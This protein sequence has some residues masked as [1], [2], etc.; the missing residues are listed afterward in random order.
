M[1]PA[2]CFLAGGLLGNLRAGIAVALFPGAM[3]VLLG[4]GGLLE[5]GTCKTFP[6]VAIGLSGIFGLTAWVTLRWLVR[7]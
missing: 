2:L 3:A 5:K 4:T 6:L 1:L 7:G